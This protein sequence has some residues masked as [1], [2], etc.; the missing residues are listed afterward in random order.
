MEHP[1]LLHDGPGTCSGCARPRSVHALIDGRLGM[2]IALPADSSTMPAMKIATY[3]VNGI[4]SRLPHLLEW[5]RT[6]PDIACLQELKA[7][8][9]T[10]PRRASARRATGPIWHGQQSWNGVAILARGC[11]P[12]RCAAGCRATRTTHSRYLEAA[13]SGIVVGCLYLPNG[14]PQPGPKFD[15]KLSLVRAPHRHAAELFSAAA[16]SCWPATTT[17]CRPTIDIYNPRR[18]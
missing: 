1:D 8:D 2:R 5:L 3:N 9:E 12:S 6:K 11:D 15:Y 18:G 17:W 7:L 13:V 10:F 16:R 14:N 4:N